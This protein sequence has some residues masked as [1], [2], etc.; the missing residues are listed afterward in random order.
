MSRDPSLDKWLF[1]SGAKHFSTLTPLVVEGQDAQTDEHNQWFEYRMDGPWDTD[2]GD[3]TFVRVEFNILVNV[4]QDVQNG[5][6]LQ[7]AS[8]LVASLFTLSIP[9]YKVGDEAG[10][11][12]GVQLGCLRLISPVR[13]Y[14]FGRAQSANFYQAMVEAQYELGS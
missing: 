10:D 3:D 13:T 6:K 2:R 5:Y 14:Q 12:P 1:G 11:D 7:E 4:S 8:G 9:V